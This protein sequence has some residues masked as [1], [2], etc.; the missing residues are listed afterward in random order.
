[1]HSDCVLRQNTT[2]TQVQEIHALILLVRYDGI[3]IMYQINRANIFFHFAI[4]FIGSC[5]SIFLSLADGNL[6]P[7][8]S[9]TIIV[10]ANECARERKAAFSETCQNYD[11]VIT[12]L[13]HKL[14]C[15]C[16]ATFIQTVS[17]N[18]KLCHPCPI[19]AL[20]HTWIWFLND[21]V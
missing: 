17:Q 14:T 21:S 12:C 9:N 5:D 16:S 10:V 7:F 11:K 6:I 1:M 3:N 18:S 8:K 13:Q 15:V 20:V 2:Q 19:W 4:R